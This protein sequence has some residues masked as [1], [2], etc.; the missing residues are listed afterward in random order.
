MDT[1]KPLN[2]F[3][4]GKC[5]SRGRLWCGTMGAQSSATEV[6]PRQGS[7]YSYD[8]GIYT[9]LW[10]NVILLKRNSWWAT[11]IHL[12]LYLCSPVQ[13]EQLLL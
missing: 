5:D 3:N 6:E 9:Y 10:L 13:P 7:L 8:A 11:G 2:R 12:K 4:D 1:D